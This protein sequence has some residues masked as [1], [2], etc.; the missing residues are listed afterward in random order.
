MARPEKRTWTRY[1]DILYLYMSMVIADGEMNVVEREMLFVC[2]R[3]WQ[4]DLAFRD[5]IDMARVV[6][7]Q[8]RRPEN[9]VALLK[10]LEKRT[11]SLA[12]RM[13]GK[14]KLS[15]KLMEH[16]RKIA[17]VDGGL[18]PMEELLLSTVYK[19]LGLESVVDLQIRNSLAYFEPIEASVTAAVVTSR[20]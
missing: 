18:H 17:Q 11:A 2:M 20:P 12:K 9:S 14:P 1:H 7:K 15:M 5:Y 4:P 6:S 8:I 3:G 13:A 10:T 19:R 16:L